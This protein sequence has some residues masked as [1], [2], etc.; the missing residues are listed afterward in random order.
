MDGSADR[1]N[2]YHADEGAAGDE[3]ADVQKAAVGS[4]PLREQILSR[5]RNLNSAFSLPLSDIGSHANAM[6]SIC[7]RQHERRARGGRSKR[8]RIRRA[9]RGRT[10]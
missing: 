4:T 5:R 3:Q 9:T 10:H 6:G 8:P 2:L 7:L 1:A